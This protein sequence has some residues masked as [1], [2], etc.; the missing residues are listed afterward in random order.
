MISH[1]KSDESFES[2]WNTSMISGILIFAILVWY[3]QSNA[4][5]VTSWIIN[6][7]K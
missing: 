2:P 1:L 7:C 6:D 5:E 4:E 3:E